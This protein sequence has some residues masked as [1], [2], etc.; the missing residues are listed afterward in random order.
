MEDGL[1][2]VNEFFLGT[3]FD[4][5]VI[6]EF[7]QSRD[8]RAWSVLLQNSSPEDARPIGALVYL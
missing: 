7:E 3:A 6:N 1:D 2:S 8:A 5:D 4:Q